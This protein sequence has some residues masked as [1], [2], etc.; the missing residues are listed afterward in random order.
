[1]KRVF[2]LI[3]LSALLGTLG[4]AQTP[5]AGSNTDQVNLKVAWVDRMA[6]TQ[7]WKTALAR[8]SRSPPAVLISSRIWAMTYN[9]QGPMQM[10]P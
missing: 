5:S 4:F 7:L 8:F 2:L 9:S 3:V 6:T 1:M 10:G